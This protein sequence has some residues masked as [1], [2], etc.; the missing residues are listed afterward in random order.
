MSPQ[1]CDGC[2]HFPHAPMRASA[3]ACSR[4]QPLRCARE[5]RRLIINREEFLIDLCVL[6]RRVFASLLLNK[7]FAPVA[8]RCE[9]DG[10]QNASRFSREATKIHPSEEPTSPTSNFQFS[11]FTLHIYQ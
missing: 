5:R 7:F 10:V 3:G 2:L 6:R 9:L 4:S 11:C 1:K 8:M